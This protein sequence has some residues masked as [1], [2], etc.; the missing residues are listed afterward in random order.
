MDGDI[1]ILYLNLNYKHGINKHTIIIKLNRNKYYVN[2]IRAYRHFNCI[3][4]YI[5]KYF[6]ILAD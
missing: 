2:Q 4:Y 3:Y 6:R 1:F 5:Y